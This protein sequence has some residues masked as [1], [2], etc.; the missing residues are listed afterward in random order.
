[1]DGRFNSQFSIFLAKN[2]FGY[3]DVKQIEETG[4]HLHGVA[5]LDPDKAAALARHIQLQRE[6]M[7]LRAG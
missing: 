6:R 2:R 1:M 7:E 4:V 3:K 5:D